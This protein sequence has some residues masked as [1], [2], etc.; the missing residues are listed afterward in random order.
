MKKP[1]L[2]M[3]PLFM[4][5]DKESEYHMNE[6]VKKTGIKLVV[7]CRG[8]QFEREEFKAGHCG[9]NHADPGGVIHH[10]SWQ[11]KVQMV[12]YYGKEFLLNPAYINTSLWD[13]AKAYAA[14]YLIP[15]DYVYLWHYLP[16]E[17]KNVVKILRNEYNWQLPSDNPATW[18]ID[19]AS[20][21]FYNYIY[22][23]VQ[24]FTEHDSLRSHQIR[25][26]HMTRKEAWKIV[27][28]ENKP[29]YEALQWYFE[30]LKFGWK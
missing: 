21:A 13:T 19:D 27:C 29:R 20:P 26:G 22:Y 4:A 24:G 1:N 28:E 23:Q 10:L 5:G 30:T 16:W 9:V 15:H 6:L 2:G 18:R 12:L 11:G 8:N 7:Y 14:T 17:E 3:V 25:E